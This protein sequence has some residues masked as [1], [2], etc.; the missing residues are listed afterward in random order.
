[1]TRYAATTKHKRYTFH[2]LFTR[3]SDDGTLTVQLVRAEWVHGIFGTS[4][5]ETFT[6]YTSVTAGEA[7]IVYSDGTVVAITAEDVDDDEY[8][9]F[10][11]LTEWM[12]L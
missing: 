5:S 6:L 11:Q 7:S 4:E 12:G 8:G 1:M 3:S 9:F 2:E 10:A